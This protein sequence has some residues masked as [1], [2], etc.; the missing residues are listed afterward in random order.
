MNSLVSVHLCEDKVPEWDAFIESHGNSTNYHRYGWRKV[1]E[2]S[3]GHKTY[4]L[5]ARNP[6]NEI[7]GVL[8]LVH[9][10]SLLFG[11]FM[12]SLPFFN[13]GGLLCSE[14][15]AVEGLLD[16]SRCLLKDVSADHAEFRHC[17]T[18]E[19]YLPTKRHKV[20]MILDLEQ[21]EDAQWKK[22]D[23]KVR[24][25]VRKAEKS[26]LTAASGHLELLDG[27]YEIFSRN[28]RDPGT[29]VYGKNF[30]RN[31]LATFPDS[32]RI[33]SINLNGSPIAS[34]MLTWFKGTLEVPWA[35]SLRDCREYC[36]NN[37]LYWEAIKFAIR[38]GSSKF[39]FGRSTPEEGTYRFKKQWGAEPVPL[40][41]QYLLKPDAEMPELN[42]KNPRYELAIRIWQK[43]PVGITKLMG[44]HIVRN[45]P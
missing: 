42:T 30:F 1:I 20:T 10:K 2:K 44:P 23:A 24:N 37:L 8:P 25:Q 43:L 22:L 28:M 26:G 6:G 32:T 29:P 11:N 13:Y 36:P 3:F 39:D 38:N 31:V 27:F 14:I 16:R 18:W 45:I 5:I 17:R 40:Y 33:I 21:D 7:C 19:E 4:Y 41:W 9:M 12:V 35:S 15:D 34:G